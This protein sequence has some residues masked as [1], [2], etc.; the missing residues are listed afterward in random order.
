[1]AEVDSLTIKVS[2]DTGNSVKDLK[3]VADAVKSLNSAAASKGISGLQKS[4]NGLASATKGLSGLGRAIQSIEKLNVSPKVKENLDKIANAASQLSKAGKGIGDFGKGLSQVAKLGTDTDLDKKFDAVAQSVGNFATALNSAVSDD[5]LARLEKIAD[6]MDRISQAASNG[7]KIP[8]SGSSKGAVTTAIK[9]QSIVK[10]VETINRTASEI[11][12]GLYGVIDSSGIIADLDGISGAIIK[13]I[14]I[15]GELTDAWKHEASEIKNIVLSQASIVDKAADLM[16]VKVKTLIKLLYSFAKLPFSKGSLGMTKGLVGMIVTPFKQLGKTLTEVTKKWHSFIAAISRIAIYRLL[17]TALK[18]IA[19]GLKE[20]VS[21]LYQWALAWQGVYS[22]AD[23]FISTMD[24]LATALLY[25]KNSVGAMVSP[26]LDYLAPVID[27]LI[28][29]FVS[30]INVINQAIAALTGASV[31]RKAI[32]YPVAFGEAASS[33]SKKVKEL[34]RTVLAFDELNKL[35]DNK[36][37]GRSGASD[38]LD[39]SKMFEESPIDGWIKA[40]VDAPSWRGLGNLIALRINDALNS[41]NWVKVQGTVKKWAK[42]FGSLFDQILLDL[43][44]PLVGKTIGEGLNTIADAINTFFDEFHFVEIGQHLS[45]GFESLID[46][47]RWGDIGR[48]L[49]QKWKAL[50]ELVIGFKDVDLTGLGK[51]IVDMF[52]SAIDNLPINDFIDA[53]EE[54]LPKIATEIG[55]AI[56]GIL[57]KS[58]EVIGGIDAEGAGTVFTT[59]L[60]NLFK[61]IDPK[62]AAVFMTNGI[63]KIIEFTTGMLK[64]DTF[65]ADI[66]TW[67]G[68]FVTNM[69]N[70]VD[71][72]KGVQNAVDLAEKIVGLLTTVVNSIPWEDVGKAIENADTSGLVEGIKGLFQSVVD[73]LE[74]AGVMDEI[75]TGIGGYMALK[76]GSALT[77]LLPSLLTLKAASSMGASV[78]AAAGGV[79]AGGAATAGATA[80]GVSIGTSIL[81]GIGAAFAGGAVAELID[82]KLI[83]PIL[84]AFGSDSASYYANFHWFGE[85]GLF[86]AVNDFQTMKIEDMCTAIKDFREVHNE[87]WESFKS[88][89]WEGVISNIGEAWETEHP[90]IAAGLDTIKDKLGLTTEAI[91]ETKIA[92]T[93]FEE[94]VTKIVPR[95]LEKFGAIADGIKEKMGDIKDAL[96]QDLGL[97]DKWNNIKVSYQN[98]T[99]SKGGKKKGFASGGIVDKG[100]LFLAGEAGPEIVTSYGG[101]TAV[102]NMEQIIQTISSSVAAASGGNITIP[103]SLDGGLLDTIIVS[104]QQRQTLRSGA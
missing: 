77:K 66:N 18:E 4:L 13:N 80:A 62:E 38:G 79:S 12:Q 69:F 56:N 50:F 8:G 37:N 46:T 32:R 17:R 76:I 33:A 49:T 45:D 34:E 67:L 9:W 86:E 100:D 20:G 11:G 58:N 55:I 48:A 64:N 57:K 61:E 51:G 70:N 22:S 44:M 90:I 68:S 84:E 26:L 72:E 1:M 82:H 71:L 35:N 5:T 88:S 95:I 96:D 73:G 81:A 47:L 103:I 23:K 97:S 98:Y 65:W 53:V 85:G 7:V 102:M 75:A 94:A 52:V 89:D 30:L 25:L 36:D 28:D 87:M 39:Y 92:T 3:D 2:V 42:R 91:E 10:A 31:W 16:L 59:A 40:L 83:A 78:S 14:P 60:D 99:S 21:N 6:A 101:E 43:D 15:L 41:I 19:A 27:K 93:T 29:K 63:K 24:R 54:L 74:R 104:A